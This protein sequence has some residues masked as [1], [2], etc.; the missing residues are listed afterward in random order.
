MFQG[1]VNLG[2]KL[3]SVRVLSPDYCKW[4]YVSKGSNC[5]EKIETVR[6][7]SPDFC[8]WRFVSKG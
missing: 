8:K 1:E 4:R 5:L 3:K 7:I 6:V 2:K